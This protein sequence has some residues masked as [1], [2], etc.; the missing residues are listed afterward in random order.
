MM[1][2]IYAWATKEYL[3]ERMSF[4][5][6]MM[7]LNYGIAIKYPKPAPRGNPGSMV[8]RSAEEIRRRRDELR[9]QFGENIEGL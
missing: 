3:L 1:G 7:Y 6:I 8:G 2:L 5:Q 9:R 4:G